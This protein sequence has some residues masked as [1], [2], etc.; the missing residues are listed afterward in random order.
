MTNNYLFKIQD[1]RRLEDVI[2]QYEQ[3]LQEHDLIIR[4]NDGTCRICKDEKTGRYQVLVDD[5]DLSIPSTI[6]YFL[7]EK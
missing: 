5:F 2:K 4:L 1:Q 7:E 3:H 6:N